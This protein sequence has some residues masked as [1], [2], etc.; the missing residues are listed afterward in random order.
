MKLLARILLALA[1]LLLAAWCAASLT[2]GPFPHPLA[3]AGLAA[4]GLVTAVSM[5]AS[6]LRRR[7]LPAFV[8]SIVAFTLF[9]S[10]VR[11][12]ND[13]DWSLPVAVLPTV[14]V[15]GDAYTFHNVRNFQYR[16]ETDF[17][18]RYYD[19]T[20]RL[21]EL[22]SVDILASYWMGDDIAHVFV[23]FGFGGRDYLA[24]SIETRP[25][26][27]ESYSTI[28][29]FFRNFEVFYVVAD[30]RDLIGVRTNHRENPPEQ[31]YLYRT[32]GSIEAARNIFLDYVETIND[33]AQHPS[34]YNT[35]TTNCTTSILR[36]TRMN[37]GRP[38]LSWKILASGHVPEYLHELGRIDTSLPFDEMKKRSQVNAAAKAAGDDAPDFSQR[39]RQGL[40]GM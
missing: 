27:G 24:V 29:G 26:K 9:W 11:P 16:T 34:W 1:T 19:K 33:L 35:L 32:K 23:S 7:A 20:V 6:G 38:P 12:S 37:P 13:R 25:E 17:T 39:I 8:A 4:A 28:A 18:P 30:E 15:D 5:F 36:H 22:S 10:T 31:V 3:A 2:Y 21:S 14:T 40:P